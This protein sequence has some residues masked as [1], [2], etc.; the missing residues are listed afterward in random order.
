[1]KEVGDEPF[2]NSATKT[3]IK[4]TK[5][6]CWRHWFGQSAVC[7]CGDWTVLSK[8]EKYRLL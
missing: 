5:V 2:G 7:G 3:D 8:T 4:P 6:S 1:M